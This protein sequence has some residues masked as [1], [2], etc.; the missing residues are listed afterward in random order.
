MTKIYHASDFDPWDD[1][2]FQADF[3]QATCPIQV[4]WTEYDPWI[5][6]PFQV[7]DARHNPKEAWRLLTNW[8][9]E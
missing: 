6:T 1:F 4:C 9:G 5:V 8:G 7:A 2:K 3:T